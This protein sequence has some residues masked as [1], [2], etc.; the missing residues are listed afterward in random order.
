MSNN[1]LVLLDKVLAQELSNGEASLPEDQAFELFAC[2]QVLKAS[3]LSVEELRSG[4]V[5]GG[6]DGG[7]DGVYT[8]LDGLLLAEDSEVFNG[9]VPLSRFRQG[10]T[11]SL[12]LIQ[13]KRSES[14]SETTIDL[15]SSSTRRL[16]D[17]QKSLEELEC[18]YSV[19]LVERF[20]LFRTAL[21]RLAVRHPIVSIEFFYV[22]RGST[23]AVHPNV[24]QKATDLEEQFSLTATSAV[25]KVNFIGVS[26]LL[27]SA[28]AGPSYTLQLAYQENATS[29]SSHVAIV[30]LRDYMK[31]L[32]EEDGSLRRHIFD[33]NVRD[34]QG[35]VKVNGEI[36]ESLC[37]KD[38]ADFWWLNNG[39]TIVCSK[40]S[41]QG[42]TYTLDDVQIVNGLQTSYTIYQALFDVGQSHF[43]LDRHLL[44]RVL[45]TEDAK[46]RDRIIRAT[47]SQTSVPEASL[48]ATDQI[49]RQIEQ[50]FEG[51]GWY[52]DRRKNYYR[53]LKKPTDRIV[54][55]PLLA[56]TIMAIGLCRPDTARARPSSLLKH[57]ADYSSIFSDGNPLI[58]YLWAAKLQKQMD[59]FLQSEAGDISNSDKTNYR[60]H[61]AMLATARLVGKPV[62]TP[63]EL[64]V[65]A[66]ADTRIAKCD[67]G[68][69]LEVL[70]TTMGNMMEETSEAP[71]KIAKGRVFV[72]RILEAAELI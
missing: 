18:R 17:L 24:L 55:I 28:S 70:R 44:V 69:C 16:L 54:G 38:T 15:A 30:S 60:F 14:F 57:D 43:A 31:F 2:E 23:A 25:G 53:N 32:S 66:S 62:Q 7:I 21:E 72:D 52:Y 58:V 9:D 3:D 8:L 34:Y 11:L 22:T 37:D 64:E 6:G 61:L 1:E 5:D 71:D 13:S 51:S 47:N 45:E 33:W 41:I 10:V 56:Q 19:G 67:L 35:E 59:I 50:Y 29:E 48:R 27:Q 26:E 39:V 12:K 68:W 20:R 65:L 46:I 40:A 4:L 42:K 49:Q 36:R 63:Q